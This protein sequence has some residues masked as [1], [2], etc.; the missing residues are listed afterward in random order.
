MLTAGKKP[1]ILTVDNHADGPYLYF[2]MKEENPER[3][4]EVLELLQMNEGNSSVMAS[5]RKLGR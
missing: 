2:K 4:K 5:L 3:A 1:E